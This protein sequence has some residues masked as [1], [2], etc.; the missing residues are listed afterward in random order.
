MRSTRQVGH[1]GKEQQ[2]SSLD[3]SDDGPVPLTFALRKYNLVAVKP[4]LVPLVPFQNA[5]S[6]SCG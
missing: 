2:S 4:S 3:L 1:L 5:K 6:S